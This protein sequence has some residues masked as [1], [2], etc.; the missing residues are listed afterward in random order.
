MTGIY[1]I[2]NI[3]NGKVYIGLSTDIMS[4]FTYHKWKLKKGT[5]NAHLQ[6]SWDKYGSDNFIFIVLEECNKEEL[7]DREIYY[8]DKFQSYNQEK[9]YNF[10]LG[11]IGRTS[12]NEYFEKTNRPRKE[13]AKTATTEEQD[14]Q[15]Y[16]LWEEGHNYTEISK[17]LNLCRKTV[18]R[19]IKKHFNIK[20]R[21]NK[22]KRE[23]VLKKLEEL[24][25]NK[26]II[27]QNGLAR[28]ANVS[29]IMIRKMIKEGLI[30]L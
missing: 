3:I 5:H 22:E 4:R 10:T 15:I 26:K 11:G 13:K 23:D 8:I 9:G 24:R 29:V 7:S 21:T 20:E 1:A 14:E 19:R 16:K 27:S 25:I 12:S 18:S 28:E 6:A 30:E 2:K 17:I